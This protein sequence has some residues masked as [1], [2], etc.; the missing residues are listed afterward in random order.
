MKQPT[1]LFVSI[2]VHK[3]RSPP[4]TSPTRPNRK[5]NCS[6][7][8]PPGTM[9]STSWF[10]SCNLKPSGWCSSKRPALAVT[11]CIAT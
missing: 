3:T 5:P 1:T 2:D 11:D 10:V 9:P 4:P 7:K 6:V 8:S